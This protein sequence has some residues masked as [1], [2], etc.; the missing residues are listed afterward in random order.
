[1][2][3]TMEDNRIKCVWCNGDRRTVQLAGLLFNESPDQVCCQ[4]YTRVK[5]L[6]DEAISEAR[7]EK[8]AELAKAA[9]GS[10][11]VN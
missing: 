6:M 4:I 5:A 1:M 3:K 9:P 11:H 10:Q 8:L 7:A 2:E